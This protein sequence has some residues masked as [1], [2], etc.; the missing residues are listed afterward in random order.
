MWESVWVWESATAPGGVACSI[1]FIAGGSKHALSVWP[2][3]LGRRRRWRWRWLFYTR[4]AAAAAA[5]ATTPT[6][7]GLELQLL[8]RSHSHSLS[9]SRSRQQS[10][11][12]FWSPQRWA[13]LADCSSSCC[14]YR[15][16]YLLLPLPQSLPLPK[17]SHFPINIQVRLR[18][19]AKKLNSRRLSS[20]FCVRI[21][22]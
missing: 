15:C 16:W 17:K 12:R 6:R 19:H 21:S 14:F 22:N 4:A 13:R 3:D 9:R 8:S 10:S 2:V 5:A 11:V 20:A 18:V 1:F 7:L